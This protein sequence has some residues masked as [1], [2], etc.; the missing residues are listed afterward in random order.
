[1][2]TRNLWSN[3]RNYPFAL[4]IWTIF[5]T[6]CAGGQVNGQATDTNSPVLADFAAALKA[7]YDKQALAIGDVLFKQVERK[8]RADAGFV[9]FRSKLQAAE[10]LA[11]RMISELNKAKNKKMAWVASRLFAGNNSERSKP[12]TVAPAKSFYETSLQLFSKAVKITG[13]STEEQNF[14]AKYYDLKLR[15]LTTAVAK[16]GQALVVAEPTF[17]G[18][19]NYVLVLPLLHASDAKA[20]NIEV[21]PRW[22]QKPQHLEIFSNSCLLHFG[23][24]FQAMMIAKHKA[25]IEGRPFS[26]IDFYRTQATRCRTSHPRAAVDC[27]KKAIAYV[28]R[29]N[30]DMLVRL[31]FEIVEICLESGNFT[32][33]ANQA[34]RIYESYPENEQAGRAIW[35]YYYALS[36]GN[37]TDAILSGIDDAISDH[38]CR[39]YKPRLM[40]VKWWA[41]R[42]KR[43][44]DAMI[45]AVEYELLKNYGNDP[46]VAPIL[47]SR[48]TDLLAQ[49][50]YSGARES[51][52]R[53]VEKFPSTKAA[54]QAHRIL[55]RLKNV[56]R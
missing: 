42:R 34:R 37:K 56:V 16:A 25:E 29:D 33:A 3:K 11:D 38:R 45:A 39:P 41:L 9:A 13:L 44:N 20:F 31:D 1:M 6:A 40:Y 7:G 22:M 52:L 49:Q 24:P 17:Q 50:D 32:L 5:A 18:T 36:R 46:M 48:A 23:L 35:L 28:S 12:L 55:E 27:I 21:L 51:L 47:L 8:Y 15:I 53:L 54:A 43:G 4:I 10:Y 14:L 26:E 2:T 19:H 30:T